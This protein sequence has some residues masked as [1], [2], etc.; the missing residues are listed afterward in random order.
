MDKPSG[1]WKTNFRFAV[2]ASWHPQDLL[3]LDFRRPSRRTRDPH[4]PLHQTAPRQ[5]HQLSTHAAVPAFSNAPTRSSSSSSLL[6]GLGTSHGCA[7]SQRSSPASVSYLAHMVTHTRKLLYP[8]THGHD[9]SSVIGLAVV[10]SVHVMR[11]YISDRGVLLH[12]L[13]SHG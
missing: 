8:G 6:K 9:V 1:R 7:T 4:P 3:S 2:E 11:T 10:G 5:P 12:F 13:A